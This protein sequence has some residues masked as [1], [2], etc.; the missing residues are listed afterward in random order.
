V[1]RDPS[2]GAEHSATGKYASRNRS[3]LDRSHSF[4]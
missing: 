2:G 4:R 1:M 3:P